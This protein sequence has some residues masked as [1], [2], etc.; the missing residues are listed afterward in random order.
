MG[1]INGKK[2]PYN[3]DSPS[4]GLCKRNSREPQQGNAAPKRSRSR[5]AGS[6]APAVTAGT[7]RAKSARQRRRHRA[8][9]YR[10]H[11]RRRTRIPLK[12]LPRPQAWI[13]A[14]LP[15][16]IL[17]TY[18]V[19]MHVTDNGRLRAT[20]AQISARR[21]LCERGVQLHIAFM[22]L[23][24]V[25]RVI[26]N[27]VGYDWS[28]PNTFIFLNINLFDA[29]LTSPNCTLSVAA[30]KTS[31]IYTK[32]SLVKGEEKAKT[33]FQLKWESD[34]AENH[35]YDVRSNWYERRKRRR[36]RNHCPEIRQ[37]Y[38][39]RGRRWEWQR[40]NPDHELIQR[41]HMLNRRLEG[42]YD[43]SGEKRAALIEQVMRRSRKPKWCG[44]FDPQTQ[45]KTLVEVVQE[46][47][48]KG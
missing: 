26:E 31:S 16:S 21:G 44:S 38:I 23:C 25:L 7:R 29:V 47:R 27:R 6:S 9:K 37:A 39:E 10:D 48:G 42:V 17:H 28:E 35:P 41:L 1:T 11:S 40:Q 46:M 32:T 2:A 14:L 20:I 36:Q 4:S 22:E 12:K 30:I 43:P 24:L 13:A 33:P 15:W 8:T 34:H 45:V 19:L 5:L 18:A 3:A